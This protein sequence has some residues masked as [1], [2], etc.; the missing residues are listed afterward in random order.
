MNPDK[1]IIGPKLTEIFNLFRLLNVRWFL[2]G[3][4]CLEFVRSEKDIFHSRI[5]DI[6][7]YEDIK[8]IK[9]IAHKLP[10][11]RITYYNGEIAGI[12]ILIGI[13]VNIFFFMD[14][15]HYVVEIRHHEAINRYRLLSYEPEIITDGTEEKLFAEGN[16]YVLKRRNK[17][18]KMLF[19]KRYME[20]N[21]KWDEWNDPANIIWEDFIQRPVRLI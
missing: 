18:C 10:V 6:G 21:K 7:V 13:Q 9:S 16:L 12:T 14:F 17:Y 15:Y 4:S 2:S 19:G 1:V 5:I 11:K 3:S 20:K 8:K